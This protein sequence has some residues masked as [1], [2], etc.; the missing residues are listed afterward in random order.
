[1]FAWLYRKSLWNTCVHQVFVFFDWR[2][3]AAVLHLYCTLCTNWY[4]YSEEW[5]LIIA[6]DDDKHAKVWQ[7]YFFQPWFVSWTIHV[8]MAARVARWTSWV[9]LPVLVL[10]AT[11]DQT[12]KRV[13]SFILFCL[14][15][16]SNRAVLWFNEAISS[17]KFWGPSYENSK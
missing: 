17:A 2:S 15:V 7:I 9:Q 8:L 10:W 4:M 3:I 1:M 11:P 14:R 16:L 6:T 12:A 5:L 13:S